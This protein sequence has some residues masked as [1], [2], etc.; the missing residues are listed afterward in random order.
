LEK[1]PFV[2]KD[3]SLKSGIERLE[4]FITVIKDVLKQLEDERDR[5][6][7]ACKSLSRYCGES[8]G[9]RA[10]ATLI[11]ILSQFAT[12]L[13]TAV[14][15]HDERKEAEKRRYAAAQKKKQ[16]GLDTSFQAK[17]LF[18]K[19]PKKPADENTK[20]RSLVLMV[21]ELLKET[22]AEAKE[23]FKNGVVYI[24]PDDKLRAIYK[25]ERESLGI[26]VPPDARKPSQV[27]LLIAIKKR[28]EKAEARR[29]SSITSTKTDEVATASQSADNMT[30]Q[31]CN[32]GDCIN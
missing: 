24:D 2:A 9:E 18:G 20:G 17:P 28:R 31:I 23:D 27:D 19:T 14:K 16:L 12:N 15:K 8:G 32:D 6:I 22:S 5:A 3:A 11:C 7:D 30:L 26:F 13:E 10:T 4:A 21:N 29:G 25:K 1:E